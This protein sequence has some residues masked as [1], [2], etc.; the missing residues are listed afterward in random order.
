MTMTKIPLNILIFIG[1]TA[2]FPLIDFLNGLFLTTGIPVPVGVSYRFV[3]LLFLLIS[4][5][6]EDLPK[7]GLTYITFLF[8][9]GNLLIWLL[10]G[11]F[12]Q[13]PISWMMADLSVFIKYFLWVLIPYYIY[14]RKSI[15]RTIRYEELFIVI[16]FLFTAGLLIPYVLG[17]GYQTYD[18]SDAGYKGYFFANNDTS[19]AFIISITFTARAL[20]LQLAGKW[21]MRLLLL[22][23]LYAGN[24]ICLLL[25]G[26]KTGILYGV[27]VSVFLL[28]H[29]LFGTGYRSTLHRILIWIASFLAIGWVVFRGIHY[30][31]EIVEGTYERIVYFYHLY[32]GDLVRL[33]TSSRSDFL[34]SGMTYFLEDSNLGFSFL[35]GQGFEYRLEN[36]G[37]FGLIEM[38]FFD[39]LFGLG[40]L[41][42]LLL[43]VMLGY[44]LWLAFAKG[45]RSI[46]SYMFLVIVMYSF[47]AGHV[48]FSALSSTFLGLVCGGIILSRKE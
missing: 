37:R 29:L 7:S 41:G 3:F 32:D 28:V 4:I 12:L 27:T 47:F 23:V 2:I 14:Q 9:T 11:I 24:I 45:E 46:Y 35:F 5:G 43:I 17:V 30:A 6:M 15:L 44:F 39:G 40:I 31:V 18:N 26:T 1:L 38:D 10:Q 13:N 20:W 48:L 8:I 16:S 34:E 42:I 21:N 25:V 19:F 22:L 33:L 36:F